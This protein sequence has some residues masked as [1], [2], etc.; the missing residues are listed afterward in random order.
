MTGRFRDHI[1]TPF[2]LFF[3]LTLFMMLLCRTPASAVSMEE[4]TFTTETKAPPVTILSD[5]GDSH[6]SVGCDL[7]FFFADRTYYLFLPASADLTGVLVR[8]TGDKQLYDPRTET[9]HGPG[10]E[11]RL[12][13]SGERNFIWEY[14]EA[15]DSYV[16]YPITV[17]HAGEIGTVY[18][19]LNGGKQAL[20]RINTSKSREESGTIA[21]CEPDGSVRFAGVMPKISGHG[22][23]SYN[24]SGDAETKNSYNISLDKKAELIDGCGESKKYILL[25]IRTWDRYDYTGLSY[26]TAFYTYNALVKEEYFNICARFVDV[27][28]DGDYRGVYILTERM[29]NGGA[30]NVTDTEDRII[31]HGT[32]AQTVSGG[33]DPAIA[34]GIRS[35]SYASGASFDGSG[36]VDLTGGYVMEVLCGHYGEYG[37][38]TKHGMFVNIKSPAYPTREQVQYIAEYVQQFE[39]ALYAETGYNALGKHFTDYADMKS[40]AA[41][42]LVYGFYCNWEIYRTSTYFYKDVDGSRYEKLTF[43]PVWDFE[44]GPEVLKNDDTLLGSTFTY[45]VEQ[46]YIWFEQAF[47]KGDYFHMLAEMTGELQK[48]VDGLLGRSESGIPVIFDFDEEAKRIEASQIMNWLR[49]SQKGRFVFHAEEMKLGISRRYNLW[50][51]RLWNE[52]NYLLGLTADCEAAGGGNYTLTAF[53]YGQTDGAVTWYRVSDDWKH[54]EQIG[55][56]NSITVSGDG[57]Y[58]ARVQ[59]PNNAWASH[60]TGS[61]F[62]NKTI[63]MISNVIDP[64]KPVVLMSPEMN[65][66][67]VY[68]AMHG[69]QKAEVVGDTPSGDS[70]G[71]VTVLWILGVLA[72]IMAGALVLPPVIEKKRRQI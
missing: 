29:N 52:E 58:Y 18:I 59:G 3:F 51:H 13:F 47:R 54:G 32:S 65:G 27:Y 36:P 69:G 2:V 4:I 30:V 45:D 5:R 31:C 34:A 20:A 24:G 67:G 50:F 71:L 70:D 23:T 17:H 39:N 66:L 63:S 64:T 28:I 49:W 26:T 11:V 43:G 22:N 60:A 72:V 15:E 14:D 68:E 38:K 62:H 19:D 9:C 53:P 55:E 16:R 21:V 44:S 25:R 6:F 61:V 10:S 7:G 41:Q 37:F 8:Y 46:Q 1:K 57:L 35:Y 12:D 48:I 40:Y 56:G 42:T 33:D